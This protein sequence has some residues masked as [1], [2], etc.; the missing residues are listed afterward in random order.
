MRQKKV[1]RYWCE[2][3]G[4]AGL[5]KSHMANHEAHCTLNPKRL[6][7]VCK[8]VQDT[9]EGHDP[10][11]RDPVAL[12][13]MLPDPANY[14]VADENAPSFT[15]VTDS[16]RERLAVDMKLLRKACDGCP[17]CIMAALRLRGIPVPMA[18]HCFKWTKEMASI[19]SDINDARAEK[20]D[21]Y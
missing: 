17:A 8:M 20:M 6:C 11:W 13:A 12:A 2:F 9:A 3:C 1:W 14:T 21:R 19:W 4:K 18:D 16:I 5:Q 10:V 7:R 15:W